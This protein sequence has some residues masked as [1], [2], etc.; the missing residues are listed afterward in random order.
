MSPQSGLGMVFRGGER[1]GI[2]L[3]PQAFQHGSFKP[4]A[5]QR[6]RG[7]REGRRGALAVGTH[8]GFGRVLQA[9]HFGGGGP[10][11]ADGEEA[12]EI[13]HAAL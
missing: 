9:Q 7:G 4:A 3:K 6:V 2:A 13:V 5:R 11:A 10:F 8:Q 12:F 1:G